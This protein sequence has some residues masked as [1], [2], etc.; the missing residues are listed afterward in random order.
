[1]AGATD[2]AVPALAIRDDALTTLAD[3][4]GDYV[5]LRTTSTG[6][7][8][9]A[10]TTAGNSNIVADDSAFT[11]GTSFVG[12]NG[13][14]ADETAPDSVDEGDIGAARMTLDRKQLMVIVDP[15][16]DANRLAIDASG[17]ATANI[18]G[19]V[20]V[21][22]TALDI[23]TITK[24]TDSIQIS[25]D[26]SANATGNGI[27]VEIDA[28]KSGLYLP[29]SKNSSI[30]SEANPIWVQTTTSGVSGNE[31][32]SYNTGSA[33]ASDTAS[34]HD[35]TVTGT[36]FLLKSVIGSFSGGGKIEVQSGPV[37]SLTTKAVAFVSKEGGTEQLF[38]DPPIEVP[39]TSTGTVRVIRTNRQG[40]AQDV[41]STIIGN[42]VA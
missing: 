26:T 5:G 29:I 22:A 13:Y 6:A 39:A 32:Q 27:F 20:T 28:I 16:T 30:N 41:Y 4:D 18:N 15:T 31:V 21:T 36:T 23:R 14:L 37:A 33:I 17:Y 24:A 2:T 10:T 19:T 35:Y 9:V 25:K 38:F 34:N 8:W 7:L 40:Q 1:V 12:V 11:V 42:D 3:A